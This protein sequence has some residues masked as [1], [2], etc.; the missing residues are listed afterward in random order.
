MSNRLL[1]R[2]QDCTKSFNDA[3]VLG[4]CGMHILDAIAKQNTSITSVTLADTS[5][6]M[7][8]RNEK[9]W[10]DIK[11][12]CPR[13][14]HVDI[15]MKYIDPSSEKEDLGLEDASFDSACDL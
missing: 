3:L 2:V 15:V 9:A 5:E 6:E 11:D 4:G 1:E 8:E 14:D 10:K 12:R 7:L 13:G